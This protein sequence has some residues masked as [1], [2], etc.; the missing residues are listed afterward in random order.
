MNETPRRILDAAGELF[1]EHGYR[2]TSMQAIAQKVGITKAAL[3]YHFAS[4]DEILQNLTLPVLD[5]LE[6]TLAEAERHGDPET[7]RRKAIEGYVDVSLRHRH[8]LVM[9]VR[10]MT[11]LVQAPVAERFK[12]ILLLAND[13]VCG[14]DRRLEQRVRAAQVVAGLGDPIV[15][16]HHV[17]AQKLRRLILDGAWALLDSPPP[18]PRSRGRGGGRPAALSEDQIEQARALH[19]S[20]HTAEEIAA[21]FGVSRATAYRI[22]K[23]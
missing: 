22:L 16:F 15:A 19:A 4:K 6:A 11:L 3:Y 8:T 10:D 1:A 21:R 7:V 12:A 18:P 20:G 14:P 17:P 13:L 2:A 23:T 5:E 9:L